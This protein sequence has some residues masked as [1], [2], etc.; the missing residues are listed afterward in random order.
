MS[1]RTY[2]SACA[3]RPRHEV[4]RYIIRYNII[5]LLPPRSLPR[6]TTSQRVRI[7]FLISC[8]IPPRLLLRVFTV[9]RCRRGGQG[10]TGETS[11]S[12]FPLIDLSPIDCDD[13]CRRVPCYEK[14]CRVVDIEGHV[15]VHVYM[16]AVL[17]LLPEKLLFSLYL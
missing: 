8:L 4:T 16:F 3:A 10:E 17:Y 2:D 14:V 15:Y 7:H 6:Q 12:R 9:S 1:L 11:L 5:D 13:V